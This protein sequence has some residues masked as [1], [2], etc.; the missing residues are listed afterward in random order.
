VQTGSVITVSADGVTLARVVDSHDPYL[1]GSLGLYC[2]DAAVEFRDVLTRPIS[3]AGR[4][5]S[6]PSPS[7][8]KDTS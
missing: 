4:G 3:P 2:E 5:A 1:S 7:P 8:R 6:T